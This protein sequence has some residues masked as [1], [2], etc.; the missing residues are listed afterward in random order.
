MRSLGVEP[1]DKDV[2]KQ[3]PRNTKEPM[4]TRHLI[5]NVLLSASIIILGTLWVYNRE[6]PS[7]KQKLVFK[8]LIY[9][10]FPCIYVCFIS[11]WLMEILREIL[12]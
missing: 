3:K 12:P 10:Y 6:V 8:K 4:I 1:V 7:K 9:N 11:R 5:I 2:L